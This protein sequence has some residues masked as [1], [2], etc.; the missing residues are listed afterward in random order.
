MFKSNPYKKLSK[1]YDIYKGNFD[2]DIPLY[3]AMCK[4]KDTILEIGCG[5]GRVLK[6]FLQAGHEITGADISEEML[7]IAKGKLSN[8]LSNGKLKLISHDFRLSPIDIQYNYVIIT[9]YTFNYL[10]EYEEQL[11]FLENVYKSMSSGSTIIL[12]LFYPK[13]LS[14]RNLENNLEERFFE[15]NGRKIYLEQKE[16]IKENIVKRIQFFSENKHKEKVVSYRRFVN[17]EDINSLLNFCGFANIM[18]TDGYDL[19]KFHSLSPE[20]PIF[21]NFIVKAKK[22]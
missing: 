1:Y 15:S 21:M 17:K 20:E 2:D 12:D 8:Y 7:D 18:F 14:C 16:M 19:N 11:N 6:A 3:L 13:P 5:T 9:Y 22:L 4:K 10:L